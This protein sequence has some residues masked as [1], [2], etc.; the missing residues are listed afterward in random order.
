MNM[1]GMTHDERLR[2]LDVTLGTDEEIAAVRQAV[3]KLYWKFAKTYSDFCPH[4]YTV[5]AWR[6]DRAGFERIVEH[7]AKYGVDAMYG[8]T[9]P[10]RYWFDH[11]EGYYYFIFDHHVDENGRITDKC[12]MFNRSRIEW[13]DWWIEETLLGRTL[14]CKTRRGAPRAAKIEHG[15]DPDVSYSK[16]KEDRK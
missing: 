6:G 7:V 11:E 1:F 9:G 14:H 13:T 2:G 8:K 16:K 5:R 12:T 15:L 3:K 10:N 4:E